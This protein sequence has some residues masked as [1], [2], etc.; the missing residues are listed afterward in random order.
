M[1]KT[2]VI[3]VIALL[4][5]A[6]NA[7]QAQ[8]GGLGK[9][10]AKVTAESLSGDVTGGMDFFLEAAA[11]YANAVCPKEEAASINADVVKLKGKP[12]SA[13]LAE[14]T[15]KLREKI[16]AKSKRGEKLDAEAKE[17]AKKGD[18]EFAK[19]VAKWAILGGSIAMAAKDGKADA[20]LAAAIPVAQQAVKDLPQVK[21]MSDAM[22]ALNKIK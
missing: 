21:K 18:A 22:K 3:A 19:G 11:C 13:S 16:E 12:D 10:G 6:P 15:T 4:T 1:K 14:V 7:T 2:L 8:L 9:L 5:L 20:A 17:W